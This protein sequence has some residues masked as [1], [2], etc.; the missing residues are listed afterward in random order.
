MANLAKPARKFIRVCSKPL[1]F[2]PN[3][4][5]CTEKKKKKP[6][7]GSESADLTPQT[8]STTGDTEQINAAVSQFEDRTRKEGRKGGV[9]GRRKEE[10][11]ERSTVVDE[12]VD[13]EHHQPLQP[14]DKLRL[15]GADGVLLAHPP[16]HHVVQLVAGHRAHP[17]QQ[18]V[19]LGQR[20][21][22][23]ACGQGIGVRER[24][25]REFGR[26]SAV[27]R[28]HVS[29]FQGER[30]GEKMQTRHKSMHRTGGGWRDFLIRHVRFSQFPTNFNYGHNN[31]NHHTHASTSSAVGCTGQIKSPFTEKSHRVS[32]QQTSG[33]IFFPRDGGGGGGRMFSAEL[34]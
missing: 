17:H 32:S 31:N 29:N 3:I 12:P 30:N 5:K 20:E 13:G 1:Y 34:T 4:N 33:D 16:L 14:L 9:E 27:A 8:K 28:T 18:R 10:R 7:R 6:P 2:G 22:A 26:G 21:A 11:S 25:G 23:A 15:A 19:G 24:N